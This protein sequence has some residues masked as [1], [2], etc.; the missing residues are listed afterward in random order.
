MFASHEAAV[1]EATID[2]IVTDQKSLA[3]ARLMGVL[4]QRGVARFSDVVA[5]LLQP[6]M[7]RETN[8][9]DICVDLAKAEKI[10]NTWGEGNRKP[11]DDDLIKLKKA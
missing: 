8:I 7:L 1:Q 2:E 6:Y 11:H 9:K 3:S 10:E 4:I 5:A